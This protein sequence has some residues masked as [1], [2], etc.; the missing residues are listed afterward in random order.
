[1][2]V[3]LAEF[4]RALDRV[5]PRGMDVAPE[6]RLEWLRLARR[7]QS[8][9]EALTGLLTAEADLA[10]ASLRTAG[11]PLASWLGMGETLSRK[12]AAGAVLRARS[13]AE[14]PRVGRA[15]SAGQINTGQAQAISRV[16]GELA[17]QLD[18]NQQTHAEE[19]MLGLASQL[20]SQELASAAGRV[21]A[22]VVPVVAEELD[23]QRLQ[24]AAEMA[25]RQRSLRFFRDGASIRFDGSLPRLEGEAFIALVA[26]H[27]EARRRTAIE[28][29]DP[30]TEATAEQRRADA[31]IALLEAARRSKPAPGVGV[32]RIVVKLDYDKLKDAA[33]GAGI[34]IAGGEP[35]SAGDL[36]RACCDAELVPVV[37]GSNSEVLD[38]G[39]DHRLVTPPIRTAL[40]QRDD[41]CVFPG[42]DVPDTLC[43]AHHIEPWWLGGPTSL[44]NLVLLCHHHH[45]LVKPAKFTTRDQWEVR[46]ADDDLPELIPPKRLDRQRRPVR[47]RKHGGTGRPATEPLDGEQVDAERVDGG[48]GTTLSSGGPVPRPARAGSV[49]A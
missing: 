19:V 24:R 48:I 31:L 4:D 47:H 36:R 44:D 3:L 25:H 16:L 15:A 6:T 27:H 41:G 14:H 23:G 20:D 30:L 26:A 9:I 45:G 34:L 39:R 7:V 13:L 32:A 12:E 49:A 10:Q 21:L 8:R 5:E 28:A 37:L 18:A 38:V 29:R 46:I 22:E 35:L 17:P 43:D 1:A 11:T 42:C 33:A 40:T 2:G